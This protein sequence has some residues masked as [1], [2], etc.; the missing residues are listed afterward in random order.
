MLKYGD[1]EYKTLDEGSV[2][3]DKDILSDYIH[4]KQQLEEA[5]R[6]KLT[7]FTKPLEAGKSGDEPINLEDIPF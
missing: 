4:A 3:V 5:K 1:Y 6:R 7:I 2:E